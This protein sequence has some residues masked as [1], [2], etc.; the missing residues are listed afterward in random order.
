M[1]DQLQY[2]WCRE[3]CSHQSSPLGVMTD[4][5]QQKH[6]V[7]N[8]GVVHI[9]IY[10]TQSKE[11]ISLHFLFHYYSPSPLPLHKSRDV[12]LSLHTT[13]SEEKCWER[14]GMDQ[15]PQNK[16]RLFLLPTEL[17]EK[18]AMMCS[19]RYLLPR[20]SCCE[21]SSML[22]LASLPPADG[23]HSLFLLD[24]APKPHR[25][26]CPVKPLLFLV[27]VH[28]CLLQLCTKNFNPSISML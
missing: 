1:L 16:H 7:M 11:Y 17:M 23:I 26:L 10:Q 3:T 14:R 24:N 12:E 27:S 2:S 15:L 21:A 25:W 20:Q 5:C 19:L 4:L 18:I 22:G 8:R 9:L 28:D 6:T 13:L